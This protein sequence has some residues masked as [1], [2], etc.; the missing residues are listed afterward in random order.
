MQGGPKAWDTPERFHAGSYPGGP[1]GFG[2]ESP[3]KR[4]LYRALTRSVE[5]VEAERS[6]FVLTRTKSKRLQRRLSGMLLFVL[7]GFGAGLHIGLKSVVS[8][9]DLAQAT[10]ATAQS[11]DPSREVSRL[12]VELWKMEE[13]DVQRGPSAGRR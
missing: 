8:A 2:M 11:F 4:S 1:T 9:E 6:S 12:L 3:G 7:I 10:E 5:T 13:L